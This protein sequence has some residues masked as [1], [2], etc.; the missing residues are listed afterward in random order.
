MRER[1][2]RTERDTAASERS[3]VSREKLGVFV[4]ETCGAL[5]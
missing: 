5:L 4:H 1:E 3:E 2:V